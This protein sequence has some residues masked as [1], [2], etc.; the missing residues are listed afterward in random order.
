VTAI[1][2]LQKFGY[3]FQGRQTEGVNEK[4]TRWWYFGIE[5]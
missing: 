3:V 4:T 2:V 1:L 5:N